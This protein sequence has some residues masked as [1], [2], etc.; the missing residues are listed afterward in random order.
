M[1]HSVPPT[2]QQATANP[3]LWQRLLDTHG[4][5]WVS[6]LWDHCFF[7][8]DPGAYKVLFVPTKSLFPQSCVSS[9]SFG[10]EF[11]KNIYFCF[12]Y[13]KAFDCVDHNKLWKILQEMGIPDHLSCHLRNLCGGQEAAELDMEQRA[14]SKLGKE[15]VKAVYCHLA[16]L[17][18]MQSTSCKMH[19]WM[20]SLI[21]WMWVWVNS[22]RWWWT[23]GP[24]VL[25]LM[26]LQIV[27]HDWATELTNQGHNFGA[28][29]RSTLTEFFLM[30]TYIYL[31]IP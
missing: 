12:D 17:T 26:G 8:L 29:T 23:G 7:L 21:R 10:R 28:R 11:Q 2:L 24:G 20:A 15:Y 5:V 6:F 19:G 13:A 14:G 25:W 16:Y 18:H 9:G 22:G 30:S 4:Q 3:C 27:G 31:F 1:P